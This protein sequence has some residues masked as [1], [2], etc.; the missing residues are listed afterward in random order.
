M[1]TGAPPVPE[2]PGSQA[3]TS[4]PTLLCPTCK[5]PYQEGEAKCRR[6]GTTFGRVGQTGF[7]TRSHEPPDPAR[8]PRGAVFLPSQRPVALQIKGQVLTLPLVESVVIGRAN[9]DPD[10]PQ[11]DV[12]LSAFGAIEGGVSR[13]HLRITTRGEMVYVSDLGSSNGTWLN[14]HR[15][16]SHTQRLVRSGD[17][18]ALGTLKIVVTFYS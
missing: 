4:V 17:E 13:R 6:C 11:P 10:S 3:V 14:G 1:S 2:E 9:D 5:A 16:F 7:L 8:E 18:L 15:L 12:D